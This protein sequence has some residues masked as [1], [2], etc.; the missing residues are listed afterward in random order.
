M[1][2][3]PFGIILSAALIAGLSGCSFLSGGTTG[4]WNLLSPNSAASNSPKSKGPEVVVEEPSIN[5]P[6]AIG[7]VSIRKLSHKQDAPPGGVAGIPLIG[8]I[9]AVL[10][11]AE[12]L[13]QD[14]ETAV[15]ETTPAVAPNLK[16][17]APAQPIQ[18][19]QQ[20][21]LR[22]GPLPALDR[23]PPRLKVHFVHQGRLRAYASR[24]TIRGTVE[25]DSGIALVTVNGYTALIQGRSFSKRIRVPV[26]TQRSVVQALDVHGNASFVQFDIIRRDGRDGRGPIRASDTS[27]KFG[28]PETPPLKVQS[29]RDIQEPGI[30]MV[31][32]Q[33]TP[34]MHIIRMPN[35]DACNKTV[36][37]SEN[38]SCTIYR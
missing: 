14:E 17:T 15:A 1:R 38:A 4:I 11:G 25:D 34:A 13:P 36:E 18:P 6:E 31:L 8:P 22:T 16:I 27:L 5:R 19:V 21:A 33:G 24:I 3:G 12:A 37:F 20:A 10:F 26:G 23:R 29:L 35:I 7:K 28:N 30:Y 32:M 9:L 2:H